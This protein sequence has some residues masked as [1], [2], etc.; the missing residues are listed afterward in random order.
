M[1]NK[2]D[3]DFTHYE[4]SVND[5][6]KDLDLKGQS[7][8]SELKLITRHLRSRTFTVKIN[9]SELVELMGG[10]TEIQTGWISNVVY[11]KNEG[12]ISFSLDR[13][14]KPFLLGLRE[15]FTELDFNNLKQLKSIYSPKLYELLKQYENIKGKK[16]VYWERIFTVENLR[17]I[18]CISAD[19]YKL[20]GHFKSRVILKSQRRDKQKNRFVF[21]IRGSK[22][23]QKNFCNKI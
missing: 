22:K 5:F 15:R 17:H 7:A 6:M 20:Y 11:R 12:T 4:F 2:N 16:N 9:D 10:V 8:Y 19:E 21:R 1:I 3:T 18:L 23:W 14:L 13:L